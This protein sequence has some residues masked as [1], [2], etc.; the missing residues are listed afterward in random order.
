MNDQ[1]NKDY[2]TKSKL[3]GCWQCHHLDTRPTSDYEDL[4]DDKKFICV[5]ASIH[6]VI[7]TLYKYYRK[8]KTVMNRLRDVL[9]KMCQYEQ[10]DLDEN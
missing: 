9:E 2:I 1:D 6:D 10:G 7:H 8:D 4:S 5:L 3:S